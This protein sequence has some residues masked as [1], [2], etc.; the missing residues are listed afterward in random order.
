MPAKLP[1]E[2]ASVASMPFIIHFQTSKS[3]KQSESLATSFQTRF[4]SRNLVIA[5]SFFPFVTLIFTG[6]SGFNRSVEKSKNIRTYNWRSSEFTNSLKNINVLSF[7]NASSG[8]SWVGHRFGFASRSS[9][10]DQIG[11]VCTNISNQPV[12]I[13][14]NFRCFRKIFLQTQHFPFW[15]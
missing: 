3:Q 4:P 1:S 5:P 10:R 7:H 6:S 13:P 9:R 14:K 15:R 2:W 12:P 11:N 8:D